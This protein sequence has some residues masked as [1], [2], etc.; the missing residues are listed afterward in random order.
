MKVLMAAPFETNGRYRGGIGSVANTIM[1]HDKALKANSLDVIEFNTC[2]IDRQIGSDASIG[3]DN[4]KNSLILYSTIC[5]AVNESDAEVLYY[6]SS[7]KIALLKDLLVL[8]H[9]KRKTGIKTVIHIHFAEYQ[10]IMTGNRLVDVIILEILKK[11]VDE[12]V[13]LSKGTMESFIEHG[14]AREKCN[15]IYNFSTLDIKSGCKPKLHQDGAPVKFLFIGAIC[16]RK[17]FFDLADVMSSFKEDNIQ[18]H[19]CGATSNQEAEEHFAELWET[20][21]EKLVFHGFVSGDERERVYKDAD[22][23]ILPSY[24][25]GLPMV[26]ME[27]FSAGCAVISTDVGA[28]PEIVK[29]ENGIIIHPGDKDALKQ[30]MQTLIEDYQT[31]KL[32]QEYNIN[33]ARDYTCEK[34]IEKLSA[35]CRKG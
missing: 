5:S 22:I 10:K 3:L 13:F 27:A 32:M 9:A 6:H 31:L 19:V 25:E 12:V 26:I 2:A 33:C 20:L 15:V 18:L 16:K 28:I 8:R 1:D 11:D 34:F 30:A 23:L 21:G 4:I 17:G 35:V 29:K 7:V 14:L 24:G